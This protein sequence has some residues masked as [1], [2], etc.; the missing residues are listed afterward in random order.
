ML[1][2]VT[3]NNNKF[4]E[5]RAILGNVEQL[6]INLS[7]IQE[8]DPKKI[9][10]KKLLEALK[11]KKEN[12]IV[13]DTCMYLDCMKGLPGPLIK[14]FL[15]TIGIE[16]IVELTEKLRNNRAEVRLIV[17]YAKNDKEISFFEGSDSGVIVRPRGSLK[18]GFDPI[19]QPDG[20]SKTFGEMKT[21]DKI[22][23]S[24]RRKALDK[25]KHFLESNN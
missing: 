10:K 8:L 4:E 17:G 23:I 21:E 22:K 1:Y 2:Y 12:V 3:G 13:E 19:F 14:W 6:N 24:H 5:A 18:F 20:H 9:I 15:Q 25:L 11:H 16:G 7:E